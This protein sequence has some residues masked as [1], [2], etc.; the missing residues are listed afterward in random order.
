[1]TL[2]DRLVLLLVIDQIPGTT[3]SARFWQ[4]QDVCI[5]VIQVDFRIK[6]IERFFQLYS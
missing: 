3:V 5:Q 1:M 4:T 6:Q 2:A